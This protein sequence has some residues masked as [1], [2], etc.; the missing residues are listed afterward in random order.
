MLA[1]CAKLSLK[2]QNLVIAIWIA[3]S[4]AGVFGGVQ[5][6]K[7]LTTSLD[8][9]GSNSAA[10]SKVLQER[11]SE[12]PEGSFTVLYRY[13]QATPEQI[14]EFKASLARA[15]EVI[16][17]SEITQEKAFAG[18]LYATIGTSLDLNQASQYTE[19]LRASLKLN[20]LDAAL[21]TGPPAIKS[22]VVPIL[23][24]DL[25]RGQLIAFA[26]A[27]ILLIAALG[28]SWAVLI[29]LIFAFSTITT[30]LGIIYLLAQKF[31]MVLYVPNI[32]EL[33]GLGLAIDYSLIMVHQYRQNRDL[34]VDRMEKTMQT[35]GRTAVI[36]GLTVALGL[37]TL[38]FVP[39]PFVRSLGLASLVVPLVS[40]AA[41]ATLQPILLKYL[42]GDSPKRFK[43]YLGN[44]FNFLTNIAISKPKATFAM[45]VTAIAISLS[46]LLWLQVTP[47]SLS[48]IPSHLESA[49]ALNSVTSKVG[50][51]VITPHEMVIDLGEE[52]KAQ[53]I[54]D[55]RF[56]FVKKIADNPE[57]FTVASGDKWPYV[58]SSG[59]F[60]RI[61]IFGQHDL[62]A[63]ETV[64][65]VQQLRNEYIP[66]SGF[67]PNALF[68]LGGAPAQGVD[69]LNALSDSF[70][71]VVLLILVLTFIVLMRTF[72]SVVLSAKA[73]ILD[74]ISIGVS[75]SF[76]VIIFKLGVGTYQTE[77]IEAWVMILLFA[78]LFGLS[79]DYEIFIVSRIREARDQGASN[80]EAIRQGMQTSGTV[81]IAAALIFISAVTGLITGHFAGLQQLGIG[82]AVGVIVDATIVRGLLLPS[83]MVLLGKW[84]WWMPGNGK[85]PTLK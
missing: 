40:I 32:V 7:H 83:V 56:E 45:T 73:I 71:L 11:F 75:F 3:L 42:G 57:V 43:G 33:I 24:S 69:L 35:A 52:L 4:A 15:V 55:L 30:S 17:S 46:S 60:I 65:L 12:N 50:V 74:L 82:L 72:R 21:V 38:I 28:F 70:P 29:P 27:V 78:I 63:D 25:Q 23:A 81:V 76:L 44:N 47:S 39:I 41:A 10:A 26:L 67:P 85:T 79:M 80:E 18:T 22:D 84:N 64:G 48:A 20:S 6:D 16:P 58:D 1:R 14:L 66:N 51:G 49:Q 77:Q 37:A 61:Y 62:G 8:I 5:L 34:T 31:L 36:S 68:Y 53:E 54:S 13:K 59:R 19:D 2:A 9:P